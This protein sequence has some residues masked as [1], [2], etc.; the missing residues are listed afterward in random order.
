[1]YAHELIISWFNVYFEKNVCNAQIIY[2]HSMKGSTVFLRFCL[3]QP[4]LFL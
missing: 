2:V 3:L 4:C 1:M